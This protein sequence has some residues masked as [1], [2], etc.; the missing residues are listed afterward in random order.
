[1]FLNSIQLDLNHI[2]ELVNIVVFL[3]K[4]PKYN[5][6][7]KDIDNM[8]KFI[9]DTLNDKLYKD[10]DQVVY[11]YCEKR[12]TTEM[13]HIVFFEDGNHLK[14]MEK[15]IKWKDKNIN[16]SEKKNINKSKNDQI[17]IIRKL[18]EN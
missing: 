5:M 10:D 8:G 14:M 6:C 1:M 18:K 16:K 12:Y 4:C 15:Q 11:L 2:I 13:S 17:D 9:S 3:T 7:R